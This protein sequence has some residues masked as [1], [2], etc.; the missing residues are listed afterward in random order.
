MSAIPHTSCAQVRGL[1]WI[2]IVQPIDCEALELHVSADAAQLHAFNCFQVSALE[3]VHWHSLRHVAE[4]NHVYTDP[5][6][7]ANTFFDV[8]GR[9]AAA[10]T[11]PHCGA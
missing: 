1:V 8:R 11:T 2:N 4:S 10:P 9:R 7:G 5:H 6:S 3:Y